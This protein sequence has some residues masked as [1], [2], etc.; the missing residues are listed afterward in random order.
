MK[1]FD[2]L[3]RKFRSM[4]PADQMVLRRR[5]L[6]HLLGVAPTKRASVQEVAS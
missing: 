4:S 5:M 1:Q 6:W 3:L 2:L